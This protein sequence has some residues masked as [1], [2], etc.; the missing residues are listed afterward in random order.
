MTPKDDFWPLFVVLPSLL[1]IQTLPSRR[2][3]PVAAAREGVDGE[4]S[5]WWEA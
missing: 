3:L 1:G 2:P 4:L 5:S